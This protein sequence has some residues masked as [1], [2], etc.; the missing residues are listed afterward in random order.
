MK[1]FIWSA[2]ALLATAVVSASA[3]DVVTLNN[4]QEFDAAINSNDLVLL[5]F[6]APWCPHCQSLKPEYEKAATELQADKIMLAEVDCTVNNVICA[7][8]NVQ[9]YPTMQMFRK[10]R[11]SDIY[12]KER[13]SDSITKYMRAHLLSDLTEIKSKTE[14]DNLREKEALLAVAYISPE[15]KSSLDSWK[16]LSEKLVDDFAFGVVTD[17]SIMQ[18]ENVAS[19]PSVV[20]YKHFD[21]LRDVRTGS[22]VPDQIEDFI[23]VNAVPLLAEV[24]SHTFMDYVDAG[25]PLAYIFSN[26]QEMKSQMHQLFWPLAQKY[27][28][29]F[30]FAHI[31]ANQYASQADFLSLNSTWPAVAVHNFKTGARFPLDQSKAINEQ[32]VSFFL[33]KIVQGQAEPALKSQ[34]F[35]VRKPEDAVKVV[36]GKDFEDI[37]MDK[38]KDVLLEIYAPWCGHCQALAPTYQQLGQVMQVNNA[39]KDHG[40]V[41]AKM[42]GTVNDVPLSAGFSVKGYPTIKLF[43]ANTNTIVDYTG[44]R[45]LHD[46]VKFLNDHSTKQSLKIDLTSLPQPGEKMIEPSEQEAIEKHDEL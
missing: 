1:S 23:K 27:K 15:D 13:K 46:F 9:G 39:E 4:M 41:I 12:N 38:S 7:K 10:G 43:K 26:S 3:G 31:D 5:K 29:V 6:Y 11:P 36:V 34:S 30:S 33:D 35:P 25:R 20:L 18:A 45:T 21:N 14:L 17:Q 22:I 42:D 8:Y 16:A 2:I 37:V 32:E 28:G 44:Q 19:S 40:V 24:E